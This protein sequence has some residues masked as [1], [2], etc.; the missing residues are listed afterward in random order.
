MIEA[1]IPT[2]GEAFREILQCLAVDLAP[3]RRTNHG[4]APVIQD[5][6]LEIG[7]LVVSI[8]AEAEDA[9]Q[10]QNA[11]AYAKDETY[12]DLHYTYSLLGRVVDQLT[13]LIEHKEHC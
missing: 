7:D 3:F 8:E 2:R 11:G 5:L 1:T 9:Y 4:A 12:E 6:L 13:E 10:R